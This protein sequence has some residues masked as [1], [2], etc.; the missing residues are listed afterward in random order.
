M[1]GACLQRYCETSLNYGD[2]DSART[3]Q[4][5]IR[6]ARTTPDLEF[7]ECGFSR[8]DHVSEVHDWSDAAHLADV[9]MAEVREL[10]QGFL[11][12][13]HAL[14]Y[15]P[16]VRSPASARAVA[17][18]AP[19]E[20]VHSDFT[21][22]YLDMIRD[23]DRAYGAFLAPALE[24]IGVRQDEI[25]KAERVVML[26]FWR[27]VGARRPDRPLALCDAASVPRSDLFSILVPEYG[28]QRLEFETFGVRCPKDPDRHRWYTYPDLTAEEVIVFRTYDSRCAAEGRPFWTP[29]SAF[30]DPRAGTDSA[31]RESVEMRVL[32]FFG[33]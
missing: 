25:A 29:H 3:V 18:Y 2:G 27:N 10:A 9:H 32:C 24:T 30:R 6:N 33:L 31:Q 21:D 5:T 19:I 12:C 26:Q 4:V 22:D 8:L 15:P 13:D 1:S 11:G 17:D 14:A 23:P 16:I 7:E 20:F 28:G